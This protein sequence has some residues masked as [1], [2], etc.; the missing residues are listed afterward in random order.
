VVG[1]SLLCVSLCRGNIY[2]P[3]KRLHPPLQ[4]RRG[5][6]R[7]LPRTDL[8]PRRRARRFGCNLLGAAQQPRRVYHQLCGGDSRGCDPSRPTTH[9]PSMDRALLR[10]E[11]GGRAETFELVV[12]SSCDVIER[13][14]YLGET[15]AWIGEATWKRLDRAFVEVLGGGKVYGKDQP[16]RRGMC[17]Q[18]ITVRQIQPRQRSFA[19]SPQ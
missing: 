15:R 19:N 7:T 3:S 5:R 1:E 13:A 8:P 10:R 11:Y 9:S 16:H 14:P 4:G 12:F 6:S 18:L 2:A 17:D